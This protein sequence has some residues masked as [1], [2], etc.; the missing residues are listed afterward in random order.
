MCCD[1]ALSLVFIGHLLIGPAWSG[2]RLRLC[3]PPCKLGISALS[4]PFKAK[5]AGGWPWKDED[6]PANTAVQGWVNLGGCDQGVGSNC[7]LQP[8]TGPP[9]TRSTMSAK[10]TSFLHTLEIQHI[11]FKK[12][13]EY[14]WSSDKTRRKH[15]RRVVCR[16]GTGNFIGGN[17]HVKNNF[18]AILRP[19]QTDCLVD[20]SAVYD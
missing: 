7:P 2:H 10:Y 20:R 14:I 12:K 19:N 9:S 6:L 8:A 15:V 1:Q 13:I 3:L 16:T 4:L 11:F 17:L 18:N 5:L